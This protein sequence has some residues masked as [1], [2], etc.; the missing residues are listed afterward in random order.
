MKIPCINFYGLSV[1]YAPGQ[2]HQLL[3]K[4]LGPAFK[5]FSQE[6]MI[7]NFYFHLSQEQ[8]S[9]INISIFSAADFKAL[10][11]SVEATVAQFLDQRPSRNIKEKFP[12]DTI[13]RN[14][15]NNS[16]AWDIFSQHPISSPHI[17]TGSLVQIR[18]AISMLMCSQFARKPLRRDALFSFSV[19]LQVLACQAIF[20][21]K[22]DAASEIKIQIGNMLSML[23][24]KQRSLIEAAS[25]HVM[26][27]NAEELKRLSVSV[28]SKQGEKT[29]DTHF[30]EWISVCRSLK[31]GLQYPAN[32]FM[33]ICGIIM[34]HLNLP[35]RQL[36]F[37]SV[38][39]ASKLLFN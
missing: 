19:Q 38:L 32:A 29:Q 15:H 30:S 8:G 23:P 33:D 20:D 28:W 36:N 39:T 31:S 14:F 10:A 6:G 1:F 4:L 22:K 17:S 26:K 5:Q 34:E 12:K 35:S 9:H 16:F 27:H 25:D 11:L 21:Q 18:Y 37:I 13:F 24:P 7:E 2:C 3:T